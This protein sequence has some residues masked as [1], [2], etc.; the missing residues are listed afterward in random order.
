MMSLHMLSDLHLDNFPRLIPFLLRTKFMP[1]GWHYVQLT[2]TQT[3]QHLAPVGV[4]LNP[5]F[6]AKV[7]Y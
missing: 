1:R 6:E 7:R 2:L 5:A 3:S 4:S